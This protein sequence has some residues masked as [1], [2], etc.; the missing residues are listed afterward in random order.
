VIRRRTTTTYCSLWVRLSPSEPVGLSVA[1]GVAPHFYHLAW[2]LGVAPTYRFALCNSVTHRH[3]QSGFRVWPKSVRVSMF[4][5]PHQFE[6]QF[7]RLN[8]GLTATHM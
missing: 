3:N 4:T 2:H 5:L 6:Q 1:P 8:G 7:Q